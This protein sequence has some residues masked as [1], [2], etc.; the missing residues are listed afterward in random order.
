MYLVGSLIGSN[1]TFVNNTYISGK[2]LII[3]MTTGGTGPNPANNIIGYFDGKLDDIRIYNRAL[4]DTEI[5]AL[6]HES[7]W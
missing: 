3:G 2:D 6:Y 7:G 5:P 1:S 4:T